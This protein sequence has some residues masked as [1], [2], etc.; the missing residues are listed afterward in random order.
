[1]KKKKLKNIVYNNRLSDRPETHPVYRRSY[2][3]PTK[4]IFFT[5]VNKHRCDLRHP[6]VCG[7]G[8]L[9]RAAFS[10]D[11]VGIPSQPPRLSRE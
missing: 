8:P 9:Q 2:I 1:M 4:R 7:T 5:I 11:Q 6:D 3:I 10:N